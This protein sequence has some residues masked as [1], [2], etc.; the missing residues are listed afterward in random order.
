MATQGRRQDIALAERL[1]QEPWCFEFFQAVRL[2][3]WI[4]PELQ[5]IGRDFPA[6]LEAVRFRALPSRSFPAAAIARIEPGPE[7]SQPRAPE[8]QV[9]FMG[10]TG[11]AGVLPESYLDQLLQR[12]REHDHTLQDFLDLFNHRTLSLFYRAWEKYRFPVGF[13]RAHRR[14]DET[15]LFS[16]CLECLVGLGT[17]KLKRRLPFAEAFLLGYAGHFAQSSRPVIVLQQLLADY[18]QVRVSIEQLVGRWLP[19]QDEERSCLPSPDLPDGRFNQLGV[20]T[21]LGS[22]VWDVQSGFRLRIGPLSKPAFMQFL[23]GN[24][25]LRQLVSLTRTYAGPELDFEVQLVLAASG[26]PQCRLAG[27]QSVGSRLGWNS[28][29]CSRPSPVDRDDLHFWTGPLL[30][31]PA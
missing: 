21:V 19:L 22:Q 20:D 11:P 26:V 30:A 17:D 31:D 5:T 15:D 2:L 28:W 7:D 3:E 24:T 8:M 14:H 9:T 16:W 23:P 27:R 18:F 12:L 10:L 29:L 25:R 13:E 4:H 1:W 6:S